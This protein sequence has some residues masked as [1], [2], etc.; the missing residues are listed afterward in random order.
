MKTFFDKIKAPFHRA[1]RK[2]IAVASQKRRINYL[3]R[4][5]VK[6]GENCRIDTIDFSTEPYLI[7][8]GDH[9]AV[10]GGSSFITHDGSVRCFKPGMTGGIFGKIEVGNNVFIGNH[11]IILFNTKIGD[12][13]IIGAGS[14]VRG[15]I[16][17]N[18]V[19]TGNPGKVIS[20]V[21]VIRYFFKN[22]PGLVQTDGLS[23]KEKDRLVKETLCN[24]EGND[25]Q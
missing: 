6:I 2:Y 18:S 25:C 11:C 9:V 13:C 10:S 1:R 24:D 17:A 4:Q 15:N 19:V 12:N 8:I 21:N 16:P 22:S 3:R 14:V 23:T 20:N 5:G 7:S